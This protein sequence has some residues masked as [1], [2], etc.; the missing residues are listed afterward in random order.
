MGVVYRV[1]H[2]HLGKVA[3]MK[4]LAPET[5][6]N[7]EMLRRFRAEAQAVSKLNHPNIV[8]TFDFGQADG[9]FYLVMEHIRGDDLAALLRRE[10]AWSFARAAKLFVQVCSGL[11]EAHE[12]GIVHRDLKPE[13]L[14][15]VQRRDGTEHAKVLDFGLAK[16]RE[17]SDGGG[18]SSS[19]QVLGTPYYMAPEQVRGESL[20]AR[21][22][23]YSLGATLY[24]VLTGEPPFD[25]PSPMSVL[26]KHLTEDV[27]PP[28]NKAPSLPPEADR[29]VLRAMA[30][31]PSDRFSSAAEVQAELER[32][33]AGTSA[34]AVP[35]A[36]VS[37]RPRLPIRS[38]ADVATMPL[39][40]SDL[41]FGGDRLRRADVDEY[42]WSLRRRRLAWRIALP[43][44]ILAAAGVAAA[45][46]WRGR[47]PRAEM[48]ER[49]PNSTPA[50]A[51]PVHSGVPLRGTIGTPI[52]GREGDVDYFRV[53]AANGPR[54]LQARLEGVPGV[55]LILELFDAQGRRVA[56][57]DA[58]G[59]G[60]G[61]WIQPTS[62]AAGESYLAVREVWIDGTPP[63]ANAPDPYTV[64]VRSGPPQ[65]GWEVEPNDWP[66]AATLLSVPGRTRG[67]LGTPDDKDWF[68]VA[69]VADGKLS[70]AVQPPAGIDVIVALDD[71]GK[72]G[73]DRHGP[74]KAETLT[75]E[76]KQGRPM[77]IGVTRK[78]QPG[79]DLKEQALEA[80]DDPYEVKVATE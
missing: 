79:K 36:A 26:A 47:V 80:L 12:A 29:I 10:G 59:R 61:E 1:E 57:G 25:A 34:P 74:G 6:Q 38:S 5:A 58:R 16:L 42:E 54:T 21:A 51:G 71:A 27:I 9:A 52:S 20:D 28:R 35:L 19:G 32:A 73:V 44:A 4:V 49:E 14:M 48:T 75:L 50:Y 64:S 17:R 7:P 46:V 22:D 77:I 45:L 56:K 30:K 8:Q 13:N 68:S 2:L 40:E 37:S 78:L 33:L 11:T 18:V 60:Q 63:T 66:A 3:A 69:P 23:I 15:A 72:R 70:V 67:Y 55:D 53:P 39:D 31:S 43:A 41:G 65:S 24:R 62:L 76:A